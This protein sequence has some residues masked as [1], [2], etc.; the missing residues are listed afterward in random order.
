MSRH[1]MAR[2]KLRIYITVDTET[3][4]GGA[5][6]NPAYSLPCLSRIRSSGS[7]RPSLYAAKRL[8]CGPGA[9]RRVPAKTILQQNVLL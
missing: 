5:W 4:M 2:D 9:E 8:S 1:I 7:A 6:T 3:S